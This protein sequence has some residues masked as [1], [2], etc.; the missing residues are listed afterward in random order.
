MLRFLSVARVVSRT[1]TEATFT[2]PVDAFLKVVYGE[3]EV[4]HIVS[5]QRMTEMEGFGR[6]YLAERR[7]L[8]VRSDNLITMDTV[9]NNSKRPTDGP[10]GRTPTSSTRTRSSRR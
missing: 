1:R 10:G 7:A 8:A 3:I 9:A 4:A 5:P 2:T 6:L